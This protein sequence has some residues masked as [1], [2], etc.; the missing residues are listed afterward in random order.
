MLYTCPDCG[1][2]ILIGPDEQKRVGNRRVF[3]HMKTHVK[4]V[5]QD[6]VRDVIGNRGPTVNG[7]GQSA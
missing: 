7:E 1:K 5:K 2:K 4:E 3:E 6:G